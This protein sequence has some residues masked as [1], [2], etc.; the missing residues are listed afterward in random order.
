M[1][2]SIEAA[3]ADL[4]R[5]FTHPNRIALLESLAGGE[6][7]VGDLAEA[8]GLPQPTV[9]QHLAVLR[10]VGVVST[11]REGT[12]VYY[13]VADPRILQACQLMRAVL[14]DRL[15]REARVATRVSRRPAR[16]RTP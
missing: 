1:R 10:Q 2:E 9:S 7:S 11:R 3:Q 6:R 12:T 15:K 13:R 4:C 14:L 5:T 16:R 8:C